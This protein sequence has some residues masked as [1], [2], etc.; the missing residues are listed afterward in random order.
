MSPSSSERG[1]WA[2]VGTD[3]LYGA[4]LDELDAGGASRLHHRAPSDIGGDHQI[5]DWR[6]TDYLGVTFKHT[7]AEPWRIA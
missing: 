6:R 1:R 2:R 7:D 4:V 3:L 5:I